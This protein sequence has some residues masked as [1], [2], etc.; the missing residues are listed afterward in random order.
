[1][2]NILFITEHYPSRNRPG[3]G[4]FVQ[5]LVREMARA[6]V[7]CTVLTPRGMFSQ[8]F[9][10]SEPHSFI[11]DTIDNPITIINPR[12]ITFSNRKLLGY[13]SFDL[14]QVSFERSVLK[15]VKKYKL[16][17]DV[18]YGHFLYSSGAT[19]VKL[20]V[21][22][23]I[24]SIAAI[25]ESEPSRH[26]KN[27]GIYVKPE[28]DFQ[29][30]SGIVSVS[31]ANREFCRDKLH[32][33][34]EKIRVFPNCVDFTSFYPR[35]KAEMRKKYGFPPDKTIIA[36]TGGLIP[37]KGPHRVL[38]AVKGIED[39]GIIFMGQGKI[40]LIGE[41]I[42]FKGA[43]EH[44]RVPELLSAADMF[45]LPTLA[46]GSCNAIIEA[47][48]CGLPIISSVGDFNDDILGRQYSLRV[49]PL[50]I[51]EIRSA[52]LALHNNEEM[53]C[54]MS[55]ASLD[56]AKSFNLSC[57]AEGILQ[58]IEEIKGGFTYGFNQIQSIR[59]GI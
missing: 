15:A 25:G 20:G 42:L 48:A 52:V 27:R 58:W 5:A 40:P 12:F 28:K 24:P 37:R 13:N 7:G 17:P 30:A 47:M 57:R 41:N 32:L 35:K 26:F 49:N 38:E 9:E 53:R 14:T 33:P 39:I 29:N 18:L 54:S 44:S 22:M 10:K 43:V 46:E 16:R 8:R 55:K 3:R 11:D 19:A 45:V 50:D 36:F 34:D 23:N 1:M 2:R 59:K 51:Q 6:G 56:K 4:A 21:K 31:K